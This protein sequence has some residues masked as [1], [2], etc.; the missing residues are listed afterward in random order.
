MGV[1]IKSTK[2]TKQ[3]ILSKVSQVTIFATY[4]NLSNSI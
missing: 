4:L 2:L 1:N 3:Y